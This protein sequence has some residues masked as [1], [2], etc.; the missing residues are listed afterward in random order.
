V[1]HT[2]A[3]ANYPSLCDVMLAVGPLTV[4][5]GGKSNAYRVLRL[6]VAAAEGQ[7]GRAQA[8]RGRHME[9]D[10]LRHSPT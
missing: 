5:T 9:V 10:V 8:A 3:F 7:L 1:I 4:T 6:L 2:L